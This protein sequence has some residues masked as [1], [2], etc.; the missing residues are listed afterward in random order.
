MKTEIR[1]PGRSW[2]LKI[3]RETLR[4]LNRQD[5]AGIVGGAGPTSGGRGDC[6][7]TQNCAAQDALQTRLCV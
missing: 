1:K 3:H 6:E 5:L 7:L 4:A 2:K